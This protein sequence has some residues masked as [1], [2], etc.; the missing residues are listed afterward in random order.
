MT[1]LLTQAFKKSQ[2]LPDYSIKLVPRLCLGTEIK[3]LCLA[4]RSIVEAE[5]LGRHS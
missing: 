1:D 5:P 3:R 2:E 4:W